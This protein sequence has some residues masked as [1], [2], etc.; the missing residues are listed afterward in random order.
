MEKRQIG[1]FNIQATTEGD[2]NTHRIILMY[3]S[4]KEVTYHT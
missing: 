4:R 2:P 3:L 1:F